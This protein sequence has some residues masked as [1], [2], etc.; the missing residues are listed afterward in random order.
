MTIRRLL[1]LICLL[2]CTVGTVL[3]QE[4]FTGYLDNRVDSK[5]YPLTLN[6]GDI[7]LITAE[8]TQ[9]D[10]DTVVSLFNPDGQLVGKNDDRR[11]DIYDSALIYTAQVSGE[12][13]VEVSRYEDGLSSGSFELRITIG[14]SELIAEYNELTRVELSG[15][16]E[17]LDTPNFRIH[18]TRQG[19][20]AVTTEYL[21]HVAATLEEMLR[22]EVEELGWPPPPTAGGDNRYPI[23]LI[24]LIGSGEDALGYTSPQILIGDNPHTEAIET[25]ATTSHIAIDNDF[26]DADT[27]NP[28]ALMRATVAHELHHAIQF[29]FDG[30]DPHN[31]IYEA[32]AAWIET[33]AAG[34]DQDATGYVEYAYGYPEL[35][36]G[37][38]S[39]PGQGKLQYGEWTFVQTLVDD[40]GAST[41][42]ELWSNLAQY[43]GFEAL[44]HTLDAHNVTIPEA[45]AAYR[46]RNL[47]R[48]YELA[49]LFH[50]TVWLEQTIDDTGRWTY[51][52]SGI[53]ELGAN[54]FD[55]SLPAGSY[56]AGLINDEGALD[57]WAVGVNGEQ[58]DAIPLGR[59]GTFNNTGYD[60]VYLMVFNP[61]YDEDVNDCTYYDYEIDVRTSKDEAAKPARSWNGR[62]F[63][64]LR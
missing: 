48:D 40:Y 19:A 39:D 53:Q 17:I 59:G 9:G 25:Q 24:D 42:L 41:I 2:C 20:D 34:E 47:A 64:P 18:Y 27:D 4:T 56:Y 35:C 23:Y 1:L 21:K 28:L 45:V 49:P 50:A 26:E 55:V 36:F 15:E 5:S 22:I 51:E 57:L 44:A 33:K 3:A 7:V 63:A 43:D 13:T 61:N 46:I 30:D 62:N 8:A 52:G 12:Y 29:G 11:S 38:T 32:T 54:Y 60:S 58:V 37:T 6:Q 16:T 10:L 31:W 14:G